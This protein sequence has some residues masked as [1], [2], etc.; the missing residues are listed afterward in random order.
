MDFLVGCVHMFGNDGLDSRTT[1]I[2]AVR[3]ENSR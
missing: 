3:R 2:T 1:I